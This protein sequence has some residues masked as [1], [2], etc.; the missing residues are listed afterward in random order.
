[1]VRFFR[2]LRFR[3]ILLAVAVLLPALGVILFNGLEMRRQATAA[4]ED[5]LRRLVTLAAREQ[6]QKTM[7][8][9]QFLTIL[10]LKPAVGRRDAAACNAL[11]RWLQ[12][13]PSIYTNVGAVDQQG[14]VFASALPLPGP[15]KVADRR[16]FQAASRTRDF[17]IG[18]LQMGGIAR[19]PVTAFGYP[20]LDQAGEV[21]AVLFASISIGWLNDLAVEAQLPAGAVLAIIDEQGAIMAKYP[22][23]EKWAGKSVA[24]GR[25][26][27][28]MQQRDEGVA[29]AQGMDGVPRVYAFTSLGREPRLGF[30]Y[31]GIPT[32]VVY[33]ASGQALRRNL[34]VLGGVLL[35]ALGL[36]GGGGYLLVMRRFKPLVQATARLAAGDLAARTGQTDGP[37]ELIQ[38]AQAFDHMAASL[39]ER[40]AQ[41][42]QAKAALQQSE[43]NFR[44]L[45]NRTPVMLH[46]IDP[47]G[48]IVSV[49]DYWL[50][51]MGYAR[52]EVLG[53]RITDFLTP[54]SR[55]EALEI[56]LPR[57]MQTGYARDLEYQFVKKSGEIM[58][59]LLSGIAERDASGAMLRTMAAVVDVTAHKRAEKEILRFA[60]F[61]RLNPYPV[62]E[63]DLGGKITF[64]NEAAH[65]TLGRLGRQD[66]AAF[67]PPDLKTLIHSYRQEGKN[68][69]VREVEIDATVF[70]EAIHVAEEFK[71]L[72]LYAID[73]TAHKRAEAE[74]TATKARLEKTFAVLGD[75]VLVVDPATRTI[76]A[77][78]QAVQDIFGYHPEEVVG[79]N[80]EFFHVDRAA[81]E[82][83]ARRLF[84]ALDRD[85]RA[86]FEFQMK[87][88][89]GSLIP[90]EHSVTEIR[91]EAGRRTQMVGVIRDITERKQTEAALR[92]SEELYRSLF[93]NMLNGLAYCK[94]LFE[95]DQPQDLIYLT[96]N[97]AF[98]TLTGLQDVVGK[99]ISEV[100][101]GFR[102]SNPEVLEAYGRVAL[103]GQPERFE[104][105]VAALQMWFDIAVYSPAKE[106]FVAIFDV[107]TERKQAEAALQ[108]S[109]ARFRE[110]FNG[111][112]SGVA[113]YRAAA[114]GE[115]FIFD[116]VN[117]AVEEIEQVR[118]A[119]LLG[120]NILEVFPGVKD[121]GLLAVFQR[122]WRTGV[123]EHFPL[124]FYRDNHT[125]GWRENYVC[126]LPAGE[127]VAVYDD[128][129]ARKQAEEE[130]QKLSEELEERVAER[131]AQLESTN[132]ELDRFAYSVSHDLRAPLRAMQGFSLALLEDYAGEL[133]PGGQDFARRIN[134]AA[135]RMDRLIQ[136][137]LSN[138]RLSREEMALQPVSLEQAVAEAV[139]QLEDDIRARQAQVRVE[140]P[141]PGVQAHH[142]TLVQ[143]VAN[144]VN[145]AIKFA[146]PEVQ[147]QVGLRAEDR[148]E[149]VR[150]W[151]EDNGLGIAPEHQERI[152]RIFERLHGVEAYPGTG[153][154]L[155]I[156][157]KGVERMG[158]Q[159]GVES[160]PGQGSKFWV[161]LAKAV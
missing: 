31:A 83:F 151:V 42:L 90:C 128:V 115:D 29:E 50:E 85:G 53:R 9:R 66:M 32:R 87:R 112:S 137:L 89:D 132:Q 150:L 21:Q 147:P 76:T 68:R 12:S 117:P 138:S 15:L 11:F 124:A 33:A 19:K 91:D 111:M 26:I 127:L 152:F 61:P 156:V 40:E 72:R 52:E 62:L 86:A 95:Q 58:E 135:E 140:P 71:T 30:V 39:Q 47:E 27:D 7:A 113:I 136:D 131:T 38:L 104:T 116:D 8:A 73:V 20:V 28:I 2:S 48:K 122:V 55:R 45:Y 13:Q 99:K 57:F 154:G 108:Q 109:E 51:T 94:M 141:L 120:K 134:A 18:K 106:Y 96:V 126:K 119:D 14:N 101:P 1:M 43:E 160:A 69:F 88:R 159:A 110:L 22:D 59:V 114:N 107:I 34:A 123:P 24:P 129:T 4:A 130:L 139:A 41:H 75:M 93:D 25:L 46:S 157:K 54:D 98:E 81:Y 105:Y 77:C 23:P 35:L 79:R 125:S 36:A 100:I 37:V 158:G 142:T 67:L 80:T 74:L 146:A 153:I 78:N 60:S 5:Q 161:E 16:W 82:E 17:A 155:A 143:V 118:R 44:G 92:E 102:E 56:N 84:P 6:A 103:T 65:E 133:D 145:N 149:W 64:A 97:R 144:L 63:V 148:G 70:V 10:A 121:F 49:S 3:L